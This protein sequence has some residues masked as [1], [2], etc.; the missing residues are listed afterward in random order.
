MERLHLRWTAP[1]IA[2]VVLLA[3]APA[4]NAAGPAHNAKHGRYIVVARTA[5]DY[6]ALRAKAVREGAKVAQ[7]IPRLR[8]IAVEGSSTVRASFASDS[9]VAAVA[10][11][12]IKKI[13]TADPLK[14]NLAAP[15]LHSAT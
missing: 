3:M 13:T 14:P 11:D 8:T 2:P 7:D 1:L 4:A 5:A 15:G 9:R 12:G 10:T 6:Q